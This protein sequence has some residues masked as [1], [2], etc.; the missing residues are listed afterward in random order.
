[1]TGATE[2]RRRVPGPALLVG[3]GSAL[4]GTIG[5]ARALG[6]EQA[7]SSAITLA[8]LAV[9]ITLMWLLVAASGRGGSVAVVLRGPPV[10][11]AGVAQAGFQVSFL[12]A[13]TRV[14]VGTGTLVAIGV[15][16]LLT[17]L[18]Q[19]VRTRRLARGWVAATASG[20]VGLVLLV[21]VG[22]GATADNTGLLLAF[23]SAVAYATYITLGATIGRRGHDLTVVLPVVFTI[24]AAVQ[25]PALAF[26][27]WT[28]LATTPGWLMVGYLALVPT[29][30]AYALFNRGLA[31][32]EPATAATLGLV[33]PVVAAGLAVLVLGEDLT[34][35]Q[36][37]GALLVGAGVVLAARTV[38]AV[39]AGA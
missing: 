27:D 8:R 21:G 39:T 36:V 1:M 30:L 18:V 2:T 9:A 31:V 34:V 5:T 28:W 38:A 32:V 24:A 20:L 17:G 33:E 22:A 14:D 35:V 4:F 3:A 10:W 6:P 16:P 15:T 19:V 11:I 12:S 7:G 37:V 26:A 23:A 13:V 29:V 25:L